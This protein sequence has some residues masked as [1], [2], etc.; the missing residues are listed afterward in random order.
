MEGKPLQLHFADG[1]GGQ[2]GGGKFCRELFGIKKGGEIF[3]GQQL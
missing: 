3:S 1:G 2:F